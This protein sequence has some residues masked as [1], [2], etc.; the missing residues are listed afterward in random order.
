MQRGSSDEWDDVRRRVYDR[1]NWQCQSCGRMGNHH[2][3]AQLHAHHIVERSKGGGDELSNLITLCDRC[4]AKYHGNLYLLEDGPPTSPSLSRKM[5][6]FA[7]I[8][9]LGVRGEDSRAAHREKPE[10]SEQRVEWR[11]DGLDELQ[12]L[13]EEREEANSS[14][15]LHSRGCDGSPPRLY[16]VTRGGILFRLVDRVANGSLQD[17]PNCGRDDLSAD[18]IKWNSRGTMKRIACDSCD[19]LFQ[20]KVVNLN[21]RPLVDLE[22]VVSVFDLETV[23]LP[24]VYQLKR[25]NLARTEFEGQYTTS[26]PACERSES[27]RYRRTWFRSDLLP[28][29]AWICQKCKAEFREGDNALHT[30]TGESDTDSSEPA[31]IWYYA[32]VGTVL[33]AVVAS[34]LH[35]LLIFIS[36]LPLALTVYKDIEYVRKYSDQSP[37]TPL[38]TWGTFVLGGLGAIVYLTNRRRIDNP[39]SP[40][41]AGHLR[42]TL[43]GL[44]S[45]IS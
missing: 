37:S 5:R 32:I 44:A 18:W 31:G 43:I 35:P 42:K 15:G 29:R 26:C 1:D 7:L 13:A 17:C 14:G 40:L 24:L 6:D 19:A 12:E 30:V 11:K 4:H 25:P 33:L 10:E 38:W 8:D 36:G 9:L 23:G 3:D 20:E 22:R 27:L 16:T 39:D 28:S 45:R 34:L 2:G 41:H 21:G